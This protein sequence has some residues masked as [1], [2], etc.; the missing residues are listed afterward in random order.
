MSILY[1]FHDNTMM[2]HHS[3]DKCP[4]QDNFS[5]HAHDMCEIFYF[6][7]GNC[8]YRVEGSYYPLEPGSLMI[9]RPGE[10][11][12]LQ[13][14]EN[15]PYERAAIH[16]SSEIVRAIDPQGELLRAFMN[17]PL[18]Q[19]NLYSRAAVRSSYVH[20][21]LEGMETSFTEE[22]SR[23]LAILSHL[24][25]LLSE[26]QTAFL[27][28]HHEIIPNPRRNIARELVEYI[29][30]NLNDELSLEALSDHFFIS[31]CQLNR[32]F[33]QATGSTI[34]EYILIKRLFSARQMLRAGKPAIEVCQSCGFHDYSSFYRIYK[35]HFLVS[36]QEDRLE[37]QKPYDR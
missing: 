23:R 34:W 22:Y 7:S 21:C 5:M 15:I 11:H 1:S 26:I 31:K 20:E 3:V 24:Y 32:L 33:K 13:I 12:K 14:T 16:F 25:P 17:R 36:P 2:F 8:Q 4:Q 19:R 35:K 18:G 28:K 27:Q 29:N 30:L 37:S 10:T 6:I 9:M